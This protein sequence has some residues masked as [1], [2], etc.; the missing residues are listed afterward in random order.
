MEITKCYTKRIKAA[1]TLANPSNLNTSG[2]VSVPLSHLNLHR[3]STVSWLL[4]Q[5]AALVFR[6][7]QV[8]PILL[9]V[10]DQVF[11]E[12]VATHGLHVANQAALS[13]GSCHCNIH[14][15][16]ITQE[17]H[18]KETKA[19]GLL[20]SGYMKAVPKTTTVFGSDGDMNPR[21]IV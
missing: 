6:S 20:S 18:L 7:A 12:L 11:Q 4:H 17:P 5:S 15:P 10:F 8:L 1:R 2:S 19:Q 21:L 3:E 13:P 14:P 16:V 9:K